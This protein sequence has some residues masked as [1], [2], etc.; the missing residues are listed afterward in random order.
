MEEKSRKIKRY[1]ELK[2]AEPKNEIFIDEDQE[3][4]IEL[5]LK[6]I[7]ESIKDLLEK[8]ESFVPP[9]PKLKGEKRTSPSPGERKGEEN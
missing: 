8:K 5:Q 3:K 6:W 4:E 7:E 2:K 9:S 1:V